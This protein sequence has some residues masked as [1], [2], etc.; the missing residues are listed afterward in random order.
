M[1]PSSSHPVDFWPFFPFVFIGMWILVSF[2]ISHMG[3]RSFS[4]RYP[5]ASRPAGRVY[6]SPSSWFGTIFAS[7]RNVVRVVF[8]N[9]GIYF[10]AMFLFRAF[11]PPF[12]VPWASVRRVEKKDGFFLRGYRL[13]IEDP[14]GEIHVL[15]PKKVE[16]D[17]FRYRDAHAMH[18]NL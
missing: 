18:I 16:D 6:S 5:A 1:P 3:W 15:L 11:H 2:I 7:Y 4:S 14:V 12:L 13:D 9:A 10:Y 8:T 17:L